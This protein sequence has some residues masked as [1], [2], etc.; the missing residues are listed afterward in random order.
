[1]DRRT[2]ILPL[3]EDQLY[4]TGVDVE[5]EYGLDSLWAAVAPPGPSAGFPSQAAAPPG[6]PVGS[7]HPA[8]E[9]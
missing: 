9:S 3:L 1:M 2:Q 8:V 7:P 6:R 5:A 4:G